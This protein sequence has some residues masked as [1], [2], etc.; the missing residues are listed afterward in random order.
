MIRLGLNITGVKQGFYNSV[1]ACISAEPDQVINV[2]IAKSMPAGFEDVPNFIDLV[3]AR[4]EKGFYIQRTFALG[5]TLMTVPAVRYCQ[6]L[7]WNVRMRVSSEF[8]P[9][10]SFLGINCEPSFYPAQGFGIL[11]DWIVE[12]DIG[13]HELGQFH[14]VA[15]YLKA[16]GLPMPDAKELDWTCDLS[17]FPQ[18]PI[19]LKEPYVVFQ[20]QGANKRKQLPQD[21]IERILRDLNDR[22]V[23]VYYIGE[24]RDLSPI[25]KRVIATGMKF[26][27]LELFPVIAGARCLISVDSGPLWI[28]HFTNTPTVTILG[29]SHEKQRLALHPLYPDATLWVPTN[30]W[31]GCPSCYEGAQ[32]CQGLIRCLNSNG[33]RLAS[34]VVHRTMRFWEE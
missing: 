1:G 10:L 13:N 19:D 24:P 15:I 30:E 23:K 16:L 29:P 25:G 4:G 5:D 32:A 8:V 22:G 28:S 26:N 3:K 14:R 34:E 7:G 21:T 20:G 6:H 31:I 9:L 17:K 18:S 12:Q 11:M 27:F 2:G 33:E